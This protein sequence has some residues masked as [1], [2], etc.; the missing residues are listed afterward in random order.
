M[1]ILTCKQNP[2]ASVM[3]ILKEYQKCGEY[4]MLR[5]LFNTH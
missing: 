2:E 4:V 1:N 5:I 3:P